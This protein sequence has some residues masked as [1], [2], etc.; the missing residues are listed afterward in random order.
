MANSSWTAAHLDTI[1]RHH[2]TV[3]DFSYYFS[4]LLPLAL[5]FGSES[6]ST[7]Y[8]SRGV[9]VVHPSCSTGELSTFPLEKRKPVIISIAQF[10]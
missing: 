4:P 6:G 1:L 3:L 2:D 8:L 7:D 5:L 10:R 9:N